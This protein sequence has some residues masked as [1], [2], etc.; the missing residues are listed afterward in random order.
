MRYARNETRYRMVERQDPE[1]FRKL[2]TAAQ[3]EVTRRF[4]LYE[5]IARIKLSNAPA[6]AA[7]SA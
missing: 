1:R 2:M 7:P 3:R 6:P 4:E 5:Q